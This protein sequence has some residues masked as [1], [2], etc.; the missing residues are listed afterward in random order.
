MNNCC[1]T[2]MEPCHTGDC[3]G[4]NE[5]MAL[6]PTGPVWD[7]NRNSIY[8][9][10]IRALGHIK[11][12]LNRVICSIAD[13]SPCSSELMFGYWAKVYKL[14]T[15]V[16]Q[17]PVKLCEWL[18]IIF[19]E[20]PIGSLGFLRKAIN[21]VNPN[22][23]ID[24]ELNVPDG[25][26]NGWRSDDWFCAANNMLVIKTEAKNYRY[27]EF[28]GDYPHALADGKNM[29]RRYFIPEVEC[30]RPCIFPMGLS[31]GYKTIEIGDY[32][33]NNWEVI[34]RGERPQSSL[35]CDCTGAL[36]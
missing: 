29:C 35:I 20:C 22:L 21:F 25:F 4:L 16:E 11:T 34:L 23:V 1:I 12:E 33:I 19:G 8:G 14:P 24:F 7:P 5:V 10:Y 31:V 26:A 6:L 2:D 36:K 9:Q 17:T 3:D 15:C 18:D 27:F 28:D 30:L 13:M 32:D